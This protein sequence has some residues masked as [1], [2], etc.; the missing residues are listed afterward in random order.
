[1]EKKVHFAEGERIQR[2]VAWKFAYNSCR[3]KYWEYFAIDRIRFKKRIEIT[4]MIL[5]PILNKTH[6]DYIYKRRFQE[7]Y[8]FT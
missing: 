2:M 4:S 1:M 6:R 8:V 3:K 5:M 7:K